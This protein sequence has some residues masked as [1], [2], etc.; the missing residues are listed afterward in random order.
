M[1][2]IDLS[3]DKSA[4]SDPESHEYVAKRPRKAPEGEG[5]FIYLKAFKGP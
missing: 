2:I 3:D 1:S 5:V 4:D